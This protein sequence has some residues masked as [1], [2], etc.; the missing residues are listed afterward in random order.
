M[1]KISDDQI[2]HLDRSGFRSLA[3]ILLGWWERHEKE[4]EVN[5]FDHTTQIRK[6]KEK[7]NHKSRGGDDKNAKTNI[8]AARVTRSR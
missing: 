2:N 8:Q 6:L 3:E 7:P 4:W 5:G 1:K